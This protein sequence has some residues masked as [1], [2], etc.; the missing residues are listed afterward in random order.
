MRRDP[1]AILTAFTLDPAR[2]ELYV[3]GQSDRLFILWLVADRLDPEVTV[4]TAEDVEVESD[5]GARGHLIALAESVGDE[6]RLLVF[7]DS[8]YDG[9]K[10]HAAPPR[11][12]TTDGRDLEA[13][14]LREDC[15]DKLLRV[16]LATDRIAA[17]SVLDQVLRAA[18]QVGLLRLADFM[19]DIG[20]SCNRVSVVSATQVRDLKLEFEF[21]RYLFAVL[22]RSI[23]RR[24]FDAVTEMLE[25]L[26]A[27]HAATLDLELVRGHDAVAFL[28][29]ILRKLDVDKADVAALLRASFERNM[30]IDYRNLQSV[31]RFVEGQGLA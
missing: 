26:A 31:V 10:S 29:E 25:G 28:G 18:R 7:V 14:F 17:R 9:F 15:L 12:I 11:V 13:C 2:R 4:R 20:L 27:E 21:E 19:F 30:A 6:E 23:G 3:E 24:H 16:G 5:G 22:D 1:E 8:D